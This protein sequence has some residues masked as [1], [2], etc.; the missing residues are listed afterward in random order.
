MNFEILKDT[1]SMHTYTQ[2][3][4]K[5]HMLKINYVTPLQGPIANLS[6]QKNSKVP[7]DGPLLFFM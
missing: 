6:P 7:P 4:L 5:S 2:Q 1:C 3:A